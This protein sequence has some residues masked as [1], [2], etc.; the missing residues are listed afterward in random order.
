MF[1]GTS[2]KIFKEFWP[3]LF[4]DDCMMTVKA[5]STSGMHCRSNKTTLFITSDWEHYCPLTREFKP[6]TFPLP[7]HTPC[8]F[9]PRWFYDFMT[10]YYSSVFK[11]CLL[12]RPPTLGTSHT[13]VA[14]LPEPQHLTDTGIIAGRAQ[15][16]KSMGTGTCNFHW[17]RSI[18]GMS[19]FCHLCLWRFAQIF[20]FAGLISFHSTV[21]V[22]HTFTDSQTSSLSP[23]QKQARSPVLNT[24]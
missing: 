4:P 23:W 18:S 9:Q 20:A 22:L 3:H 8:L 14:V 11:I 19:F 24:L 13:Q 12:L 21:L 17:W 7:L 2:W 6:S 10:L 5:Q 15:D 16:G 1:T